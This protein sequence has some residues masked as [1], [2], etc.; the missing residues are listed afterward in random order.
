ML[1]TAAVED[2]VLVFSTHICLSSCCWVAARSIPYP[3]GGS[4][5]GARECQRGWFYGVMSK[6]ERRARR[7]CQG[8]GKMKPRCL[9]CG[10]GEGPAETRKEES[11]GA[12]RSPTQILSQ[13]RPAHP[14]FKRSDRTEEGPAGPMRLSMS[15]R[16]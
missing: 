6:T 10:D 8:I 9:V 1:R 5:A 14:P 12:V 7:V 4:V 3:G 15:Q 16:D 13:R 11:G 2:D